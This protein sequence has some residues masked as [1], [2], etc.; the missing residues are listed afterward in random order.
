M[1]VTTVRNAVARYISHM[2]FF[3]IPDLFNV[4]GNRFSVEDLVKRRIL[5]NILS[6]MFGIYT[7]QDMRAFVAS[8]LFQRFYCIPVER[9]EQGVAVLQQMC[10][11]AML[12]S[13]PVTVNE[14]HGEPLNLNSHSFNL[15]MPL[16][17]KIQELNSLDA[18]L[19]NAATQKFD[20]LWRVHAA[21]VDIQSLGACNNL[22]KATCQQD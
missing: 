3:T 12:H 20:Q 13:A 18:F 1:L 14:N 9:F 16:A 11:W 7:W 6:C 5:P 21:H 17:V 4:S 2:K 15:T 19:Y 10:G 22:I 8:P